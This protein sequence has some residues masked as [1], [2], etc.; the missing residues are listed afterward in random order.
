MRSIHPLWTEPQVRCCLYWQGG[1]RKQ[2]Q[3]EIYKFRQ[4]HPNQKILKIP[5]ATG[6]NVTATME[7]LGITLEWPPENFTYQVA[8]AGKG[9]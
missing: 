2:L 8:I 6:V 9:V 1:A 3:L 7:R 5:E 4:D